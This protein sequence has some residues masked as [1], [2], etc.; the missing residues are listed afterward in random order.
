MKFVTGRSNL[1]F[2]GRLFISACAVLCLVASLVLPAL[3]ITKVIDRVTAQDKS[4]PESAQDKR[5]RQSELRRKAFESGRKLLLDAHVPFEP[6][7]LLNSQWR[8]NLAATFAQM[9][10]MQ[11]VRQADKLLK[12]V[13]LADTLYLPEKVT[14][15]GDTIILAKYLIF[16]G[17]EVEIKGPHNFHIYPIE[18]TALLGTSLQAAFNN[19]RVRFTKASFSRTALPRG[20]FLA[21]RFIQNGKITINTSG[22]GRDEWLLKQRELKKRESVAHHAS[23]ALLE[24]ID[25]SGNAG[26]DGQ[27]GD[28]GVAGV[29]GDAGGAG[30]NGVCGTQLNG[31][32]GNAGAAG[33]EGQPG[34][35]GKVAT[36]GDP[37]REITGNAS[38]G[39]SYTLIS[40]GG[41]GGNGGPGGSGGTG[42]LGG[43]GGKG[44]NGA[45]CPCNQG[46]SG[47]GGRGGAAGIG[48]WGGTGGDGSD[49]ARGGDGGTISFSYPSGYDP[50]NISATA[51]GGTGGNGGTGGAGGIGSSAGTPGQ[52][53][54]GAS[55]L[56]CSGSSGQNGNMGNT[57]AP[58]EHRGSGANG[59]NGGNG[60]AGSTNITPE[61][62][63]SCPSECS[64]GG[65]G[66]PADYC[67]YPSSGCPSSNYIDIGGCCQPTNPSPI[68]VDVDG[69]GFSLTNVNNGVWFDFYDAGLMMHL[70]WTAS[71]STN[72][73]LV[74]DR[75]GN[76]NIDNGKELFGNFTQQPQSANPN[77]FSALAEYDQPANGGNG[78]GL[79]DSRD[80]VFSNLRLWRDTNHN[81]LSESSELYLLPALGVTGFDLDFKESKKTDQFGNQFRYRAKVNGAETGRW[82]WDVFLTSTP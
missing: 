67:A 38:L 24:T 45:D 5:T 77:G 26:A 32:D 64:E 39:V 53:G 11:S 10:E 1:S 59:S 75:N 13:Q 76:A 46:G 47:S 61:G 57:G 14:L 81:G 36:N 70:A 20:V 74:M 69:S 22:N 71:N 80:T 63:G 27:T 54:A 12:G 31:Q 18:T 3:P 68:L 8:R 50:N 15:T 48:G 35:I 73:W 60:G 40:N 51:I 6:Y 49:G 33:G 62:G 9:P 25:R 56:N 7:Q 16:E 41:R 17:K 21:P 34:G 29:N 19:G 28:A 82:A 52:G 58:G 2:P 43:S 55:G 44:G 30:A 79:I 65:N 4:L 66:F 72:A 78:D 37:G 42:G 23:S